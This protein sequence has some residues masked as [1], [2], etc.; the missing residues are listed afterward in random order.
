MRIVDNPIAYEEYLSDSILVIY[1][2]EVDRFSYKK[3]W[4][5]DSLLIKSISFIDDVTN[6]P[7]ELTFPYK[8]EF[9]TLNELKL[10]LQQPAIIVTSTYKRIN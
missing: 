5:T 3:Y 6:E 7:K 10:V 2:Y 1:N 9:I 8:F 4:L